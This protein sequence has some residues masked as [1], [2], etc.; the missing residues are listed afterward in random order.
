MI[1]ILTIIFSCLLLFSCGS[2][3][4]NHS[5]KV[6][7]GCDAPVVQ[8]NSVQIP[9]DSIILYINFTY[10]GSSFT[11]VQ[12]VECTNAYHK[13]MI[14]LN[15]IF[16]KYGVYFKSYKSMVYFS[17]SKDYTVDEVRD[18]YFD[19]KKKL[20]DILSKIDV[21]NVINAYSFRF[22]EASGMFGFTPTLRSAW[23]FYPQETP[24]WD[25]VFVSEEGMLNYGTLI[26]E[27]V[28]YLHG[29]E[30]VHAMSEERKKEL[31]INTFDD[32]CNNRMGY[33]CCATE[34]TVKQEINCVNNILTIRS[35]LVH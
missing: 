8:S 33:T 17:E 9:S 28:H 22:S 13:E 11:E 35:Y 26:H 12:K 20:N 19:Q 4:K 1:K 23:Q 27:V 31:G 5:D 6:V 7:F 16:N 25:R 2:L 32:N 29:S 18:M 10:V 15:E 30:D 14:E 24:V 3:N 21:E 34:L